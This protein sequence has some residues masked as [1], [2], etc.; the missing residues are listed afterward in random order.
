VIN[1][2][3]VGHVDSG[4]STLMGHLLYKTGN[5]SKKNMHKFEQVG[6]VGWGLGKEFDALTRIWIMKVDA[7]IRQTLN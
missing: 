4:K 2:V 3:V 1:L 6:R 5:V 7:M